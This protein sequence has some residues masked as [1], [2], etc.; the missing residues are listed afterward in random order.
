MDRSYASG[1]AGSAPAAPASPSIGYPTKGNA[2]AGTPA[3]KPGEYWYYMIT[4][5]MLS[6]ISEAGIAFDQTKIDQLL[7]AI[8]TVTPGVVG[9][10]R[11][12]KM[13][14]AAAS[15]SAT[16]TADEIVVETALGGT[17]YRLAGFNKTINLATTGAGGMDTGAAPVSGYVA[18]YAIYNPT[19]KV[20]ALLAVNATASAAPN[21]YGGANMPAG[22]TAS[23]LV[24]VWPTNASSQFK[25]G[26]QVDRRVSFPQGGA[27]STS[28]SAGS[29]TA[30]SI[31]GLVPPNAKTINGNLQ[32]SNSITT[33]QQT[34]LYVAGD[35]A[36][37]GSAVCVFAGGT[38][39]GGAVVC[40]FSNVPV[41]TS[42][43]IYYLAT[44]TAGTPAYSI[45]INGYMF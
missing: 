42:Q 40:P 4:E 10:A 11:N 18:V 14:V 23:G 29:Y 3:T 7:K 13:A 45:Y 16:L 9:M 36:G 19:T 44:T 35:T 1:A 26:Y 12:V 30:L 15:A 27:L 21:V 2:G 39:G 28:T 32:A 38:S 5:E 37:T 43:T 31:S 24:S 8:R 41:I 20:S 34:S 33:S 25:V 22:Y 6:V 17:A